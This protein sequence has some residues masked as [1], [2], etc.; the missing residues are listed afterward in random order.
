MKKTHVEFNKSEALYHQVKDILLDRIR[1]RAWPPNTLIPT[2]QELIEEF[3]VSRTTIRQAIS[4]LVQDGLLEKKQGRGTIVKSPQLVGSLG[5]LKGFAEEVLEKGLVPHSKLIRS[6]LSD[7]FYHEKQ[8]LGLPEDAKVL[9]V[10]RIRFADQTPVALERTCW[11]EAIGNILVKHDFNKAQYYEILEK[12]N[13]FL[14]RAKEKIS[15]INATI[16]EADLLGI[17]P[18]EAL[19]EMTRLSFGLDDKPM[20]Y[21]QTKYRSDQYHYDIELKR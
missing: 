15:A 6:E 5:R 4:L 13:Y 19:L 7:K 3:K 18:G 9:V 2:E 8:M 10:E 11:P 1:S 20:E 17:R 14:K 12:E 16:Y 21:T